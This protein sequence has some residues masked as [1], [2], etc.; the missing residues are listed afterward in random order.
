MQRV[1]GLRHVEHLVLDILDTQLG[2]QPTLHPHLVDLM[3]K[4]VNVC[5]QQCMVWH[6]FSN[7]MSTV[8]VQSSDVVVL[9]LVQDSDHVVLLIFDVLGAIL[10]GPIDN[11]RTC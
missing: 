9:L 3:E 4:D 6:Q 11:G 10:D 7:L 8:R 2:V 1:S 5:L